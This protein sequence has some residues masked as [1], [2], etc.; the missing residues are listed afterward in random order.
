[1]AA[2]TIDV[3]AT[4]ALIVW[5]RTHWFEPVHAA[6]ATATTD[7]T[8]VTAA[9][10]RGPSR[11]ATLIAR[12]ISRWRTGAVLVQTMNATHADASRKSTVS[13]PTRSRHFVRHDV[14]ASGAI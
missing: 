9:A 12:G 1:M 8:N 3:S 13:A 6:V 2:S 10:P 14:R 7:A 4:D 5:S 11:R